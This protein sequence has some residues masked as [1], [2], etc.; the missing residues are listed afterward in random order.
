[1]NKS[2]IDYIFKALSAGLVPAAIWINSLSVDVAL[3]REQVKTHVT[4]LDKVEQ[5]QRKILDGVNETQLAIKEIV[6]TINF[7]KDLLE[8]I[9]DAK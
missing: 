6:V 9:R 3:L 8:E 4:R 2:T 7:M 5:E 1:M